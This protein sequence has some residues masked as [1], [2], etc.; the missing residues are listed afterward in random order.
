MQ[1][2]KRAFNSDTVIKMTETNKKSNSKEASKAS[3]VSSASG[4]QQ[5][6]GCEDRQPP[7]ARPAGAEPARKS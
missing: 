1:P 5:Q 3:D 4:E 6:L 2:G 7:R